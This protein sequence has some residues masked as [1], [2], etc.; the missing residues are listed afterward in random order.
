MDE[1]LRFDF[2]VGMILIVVGSGYD[3]RRV[4]VLRVDSLS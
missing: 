3:N 1:V 2:V 4:G